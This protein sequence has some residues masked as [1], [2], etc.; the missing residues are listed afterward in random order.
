MENNISK[1]VKMTP[2]VLPS[3]GVAAATLLNGAVLDMANFESVMI[4]VTFGVITAGAA[5]SIKAQQGA[6]ANMSDAADL[7]GTGQTIADDDDD[8][9]FYIDLIKPQER[10][11]RVAIPRATQN[12][13]VSS[14]TY[15]QYNPRTKP[16]TQG[17]GVA[18]ELHIE[19]DEG[20]A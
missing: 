17:T 6:I 4:I 8:G 20:T 16:T 5:T 10:Y 7:L 11:I 13:V 3:E 15:I 1:N 12:A 9:T 18:G 14:A 2:A 19:P